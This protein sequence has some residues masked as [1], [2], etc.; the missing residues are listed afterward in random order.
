MIVRLVRIARDGTII[1]LDWHDPTN[2][3]FVRQAVGLYV[4]RHLLDPLRERGVQF[5]LPGEPFDF[6]L[7]SHLCMTQHN[8]QAWEDGPLLVHAHHDTA[9][10]PATSRMCL[11]SEKV[12]GI[13]KPRLY[14]DPWQHHVSVLQF[15]YPAQTVHTTA[16]ADASPPWFTTE[17]MPRIAL[18]PAV[19]DAQ[20]QRKIRLVPGYVHAQMLQAGW[21]FGPSLATDRSY[22]AYF[23]GSVLYRNW[24]VVLHRVTCINQLRV[25]EENGFKCRWAANGHGWEKYMR[26]GIRRTRVA[27][28]PWGYGASC[29]R[30]V[31]IIMGGAVMVKPDT[32]FCQS[33][34]DLFHPDNDF[35]VKCG[36]YYEDLPAIIED[37]TSNW[38]SDRYRSLRE[39]G[40]AFLERYHDVA[41][42]ADYLA[43]VF[44]YF[45]GLI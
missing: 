45:E 38:T 20:I 4:I 29:F 15:P 27:P 6:S 2:A 22:D 19:S 28:S 7:V 14:R 30:D 5:A 26:A 24:P 9:G 39:R 17:G 35:Y 42:T 21:K 40:W 11:C 8:L 10:L 16:L 18:T 1:P 25:A 13:L 44:H 32:T 37:V 43:D 41:V 12:V 31:E 33:W 3:D 36:L 23:A 34:P